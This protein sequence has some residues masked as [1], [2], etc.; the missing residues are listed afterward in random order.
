[1]NLINSKFSKNVRDTLI[2]SFKT[3]GRDPSYFS[4]VKQDESE[5]H[6]SDF[7]STDMGSEEPFL[8]S[9]NPTKMILFLEYIVTNEPDKADESIYNSLLD[10]YLIVY[11][12]ESNQDECDNLRKK[13]MSLLKD[14]AGKY[15][16]EQAM[17]S[18]R[19]NHFIDG[20][21]FI[22]QQAQLYDLILDYYI[23]VDDVNMIVDTCEKFSEEDE[24][25]WVRAFWYFAKIPEIEMSHL[26][27]VLEE[28]DKRNLIPPIS[29]ID[30]LSTNSPNATLTAIKDY[31]VRWLTKTSETVTKNNELI[32]E[33]QESTEKMRDEIESIRTQPKI[34]QSSRCSSCKMHLELPS[35]HFLCGHSYHQGCLESPEMPSDSPRDKGCPLCLPEQIR[36]TTM[37]TT[38]KENNFGS[39]I[40]DD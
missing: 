6:S 31:L 2:K 26:H 27:R 16:F 40:D 36:L 13:I 28:V 10:C 7:D 4:Q 9:A 25:L 34:F 39:I 18:C 3:L 33:Y 15:S 22:Y 20:L 30:I 29:V 37:I 23:E 17:I 1:M 5:T 8:E 14:N 12:K 32:S 21:L 24:R 38:Q 19:M 35:I 11:K